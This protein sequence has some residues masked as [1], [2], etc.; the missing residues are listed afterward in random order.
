MLNVTYSVANNP[1]RR[2]RLCYN[3]RHA[4]KRRIYNLLAAL[5]LVMCVVSLAVRIWT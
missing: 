5:S 1:P 3:P 2:A 4:V